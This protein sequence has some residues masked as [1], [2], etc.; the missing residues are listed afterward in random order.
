MVGGLH[1]PVQLIRVQLGD[2]EHEGDE[3]AVR[4]PHGLRQTASGSIYAAPE[5]TSAPVSSNYAR[6]QS[7]SD[8]SASQ[9]H[10]EL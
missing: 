4:V 3:D 8:L 1:V 9:K 10:R 7:E 6:V 2:V 5:R